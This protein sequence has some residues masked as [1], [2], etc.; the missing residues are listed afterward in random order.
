MWKSALVVAVVVIALSGC[1]AGVESAEPAKSAAPV[2]T[3]APVESAAPLKVDEATPAEA[4]SDETFVAEARIRLTGLKEAPD[5]DLIAAGKKACEL[6][7]QGQTVEEVRLIEG[8]QPNENDLYW[9]SIVLATW[10][11]KVYC[12]EFDN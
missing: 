10:G 3:S 11:A 9:D 12:P 6:L 2:E 4:A 7:A 5:A 1:A 8:E